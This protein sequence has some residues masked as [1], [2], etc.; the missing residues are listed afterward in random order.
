MAE[1]AIISLG[2]GAFEANPAQTP[3]PGTIPFYSVASDPADLNELLKRGPEPWAVVRDPVKTLWLAK[4]Q[5][6]SVSDQYLTSLG[7]NLRVE[8]E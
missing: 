8:L 1:L 5:K 2:V 7:V 3:A 4:G 6:G